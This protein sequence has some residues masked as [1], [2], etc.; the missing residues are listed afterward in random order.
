MR[1]AVAPTSVPRRVEEVAMWKDYS[2]EGRISRKDAKNAK[3]RKILSLA[4]FASLREPLY[5]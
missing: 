2:G 4:F 1:T 3:L 5:S